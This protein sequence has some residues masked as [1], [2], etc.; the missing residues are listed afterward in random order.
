MTIPSWLRAALVLVAVFA[1]GALA[2]VGY[3]RSTKG[4]RPLAGH[5]SPH[6]LGIDLGLDSAQEA[7]IARILERRQKTIDATWSSLQPHVRATLDSTHQEILS[8][9]RPEQA[10]KYRERMGSM[11][12]GR[13][14]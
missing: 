1:A 12:S 5:T 3:D 10:A 6:G 7:A 13:S 14:H 2:G 8:V 11:H 9:L 4:I